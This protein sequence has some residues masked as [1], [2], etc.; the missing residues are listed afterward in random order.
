[1]RWNRFKRQSSL[2]SRAGRAVSPRNTE[3]FDNL[4]PRQLLSADFANL[5]IP[6]GDYS[7]GSD[8]AYADFNGDGLTD[9][10]SLMWRSSTSSNE[11][12]IAYAREDGG[13]DEPVSYDLFDWNSSGW[14]NLVAGDFNG[15]D[16]MDV[17]FV[18][19][20]YDVVVSLQEAD[21]SFSDVEWPFYMYRGGSIE[22][23]DMN[24]DGMDDLVV[25]DGYGQ[26]TVW[27]GS[28]DG[29]F[30]Y[31]DRLRSGIDGF[32]IGDFNTFREIEEFEIAD[33]D[34]DGD[35]DVV[36]IHGAFAQEGPWFSVLT[37]QG[38]GQLDPGVG[39]ESTSTNPRHIAMGDIN[40]DGWIDIA[41]LNKGSD[42]V[43]VHLND[44]DGTFGTS[45]ESAIGGYRDGESFANYELRIAE[46]TKD[47]FA[48]IIVLQSP[49]NGT[50][51][52]LAGSTSGQVTDAYQARMPINANGLDVFDLT[53]DGVADLVSGIELKY[54]A[55]GAVVTEVRS[56]GGLRGPTLEDPRGELASY[57]AHASGFGDVNDD[58]IT[59]AVI[60]A[61]HYENSESKYVYQVLLGDGE[62][63]FAAPINFA[64]DGAGFQHEILVKD[65]N[66]DGYDD[67]I[68]NGNSDPL[69]DGRQQ[70]AVRVLINT[71]AVT[72]SV[73][74][75]APTIYD[76]E[77]ANDTI[78]KDFDKD[79]FQDFA[80]TANYG[81]EYRV[82]IWYGDGSGTFE[83][84][85]TLRPPVP[86]SSLKADD[87]TG[88]GY[89]DLYA[90]DESGGYLYLF[91]HN[92]GEARDFGNAGSIYLGSSQGASG[93]AIG[94]INNDGLKDILASVDKDT[95]GFGSELSI[96]YR[97]GDDN[98][99]WTDPEMIRHESLEYAHGD[100]SLADVNGD[101]RLDLVG[102]GY[103]FVNVLENNGDGTFADPTLYAAGYAGLLDI[104]VADLD[105]DGDQDLY[106]V[107]STQFGGAAPVTVLS[108]L[109]EPP[110]LRSIDYK[111]EAYQ[112]GSVRSPVR[113]YSTATT[114][115]SSS[116]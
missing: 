67:I 85:I 42:S 50:I 34:R 110:E 84:T 12:G 115:P 21:G 76:I 101:R 98:N 102:A 59:D 52:V 31:S 75:T 109:A 96:I 26:V 35:L 14:G 91:T 51:S 46:V 32:D 20:G 8:L 58:G 25:G 33:V 107:A 61:Q 93:F 49:D 116:K 114:S 29:R 81:G 77:R 27:Q 95:G 30:S 60:Y 47:S 82:E 24:G 1:M 18:Y 38:D 92:E 10:A 36:A 39:Y 3:F 90:L 43:T 87:Y 104:D 22:S 5:T 13:F 6:V 37:N 100:V 112:G 40:G 97:T 57:Q 83:R 72:G 23:A 9:V 73:S 45:I 69:S 56:I 17:A 7:S 89:L 68:V 111:A 53:G 108:N 15:D 106:V 66:R 88:D 28:A 64:I 44:R 63:G 65:L 54:D 103:G 11:L 48:D 16:R 41:T 4:E 105:R 113:E 94:D 55:F 80:V 71:T 70:G 99:R 62:G 2:R 86:L 78:V 19:S 74:F 79:G